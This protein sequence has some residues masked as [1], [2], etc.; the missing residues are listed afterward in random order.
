M[1]DPSDFKDIR[2][3]FT[4]VCEHD[5]GEGRLIASKDLQG[6]TVFNTWIGF[7]CKGCGAWFRCQLAAVK[8][9]QKPMRHYVTTT[10]QRIGVATRATEDPQA[11]LVEMRNSGGWDQPDPGVCM[12]TAMAAAFVRAG[13]ADVVMGEGPEAHLNKMMEGKGKPQ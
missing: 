6:N 4:A 13:K 12:M 5:C 11:L 8:C 10:E 9:V 7:E 3:F 2:D 1:S